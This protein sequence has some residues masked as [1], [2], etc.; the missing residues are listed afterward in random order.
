[1]MQDW[2]NNINKAVML[3]NNALAYLKN[4]E[5]LSEEFN[6]NYK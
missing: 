4:N 2:N 1:M 5:R 3:I 6:Y